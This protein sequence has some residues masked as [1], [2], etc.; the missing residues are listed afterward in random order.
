MLR[1]ISLAWD[2]ERET[3]APEP[4]A[5]RLLSQIIFASEDVDGPCTVGGGLRRKAIDSLQ[6]RADDLFEENR[7]EIAAEDTAFVAQRRAQ[8]RSRAER[9]RE[10]EERR[11]A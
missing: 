1:V 8:I 5:E 2:C 10:S 6:A 3:M 9:D 11:W 7:R 4:A